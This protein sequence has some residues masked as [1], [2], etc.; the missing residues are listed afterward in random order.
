[1]A[2]SPNQKP[3]PK[4]AESG[5]PAA[6][7]NQPAPFGD[8]RG[9]IEALRR[10][11]EIHDIDVEVD[12]ECELG[13]VT[14]KAFGNGDGP[15][16]MFN[17]IKDY[18]GP[19]ARCTKLFTGGLSSYSRVAMMF[20]LPKDASI[21]EM[22][23][24]A[25]KAYA[26]RVPPVTLKTGPVKENIV[27]GDDIN[28]LDFPVPK[29]H[30][31]DGGRYIN[32]MQGTVTKDP[33]T[34]RLNV[35]MYRGMVGQ[36]PNSLPVLLWR[37]QNWGL[38]FKKYVEKQE[39]MPVA[40][41]Y[42]WEPSLPF[43]AASP[44]PPDVSEYDV[45]GAI[46]GAPVELVDCETVPLKVPASAEIVIEGWISP[47]PATFEME[48]PFGEYTGY[49][50]GDQSPKHVVRVTAITHRNDPIFR[51]TLEGTMPKMLN[52]NSIMSSVQR[53]AL[54]W[55]ILER[56]GVPGIT[57]VHCP[58][59]NNGTTLIIQ[60]KQTYRGQAKQAACAIWGS[61]AAHLRYTHIWVVDDDI[62]IH[63]PGSLDWAF[64]Y[65]VNAAEDDIVFMPGT[66]GSALD[67]STRL[68]YRDTAMYGTGKWCRVLIDATINLDFEPEE[69]YQGDR[70][71]KMVKSDPIDLDLVERRWEEYGFKP[72]K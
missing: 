20:G 13:T 53:A 44:I 71:P 72:K 27:T 38:D 21:T 49:F 54:A 69:N 3:T 45:M 33:V 42:G 4:T 62:D 18:N 60:M 37:P 6:G 28:L 23:K 52:E 25:R 58:A 14:R 15:A 10:E 11:G 70:Y 5:A 47:D 12:W 36:K 64:A 26:S 55:N 63:D 1:M 57:D 50:G 17:N 31:L 19:G 67:P 56:S 65:R 34:G 43:C 8:L 39:E 68:K 16:L 61:N 29:W 32:T 22:V 35:G 7:S 2:K 30:R 59:A 41:I 40:F 9:W 51:G 24:A 46:R 66:F 48:G